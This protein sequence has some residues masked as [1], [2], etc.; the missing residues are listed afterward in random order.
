MKITHRHCH[1]LAVAEMFYLYQ[2][3]RTSSWWR[4]CFL[5]TDTNPDIMT[6]L[7]S[8][9]DW[10]RRLSEIANKL[11]AR[12]SEGEA[13]LQV[14]STCSEGKLVLEQPRDVKRVNRQDLLLKCSLCE[15]G[16]PRTHIDVIILYPFLYPNSITPLKNHHFPN[17]LHILIVVAFII[18]I[19]SKV[20]DAHC[21]AMPSS[22]T[23]TPDP[24]PQTS[25]E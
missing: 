13:L 18:M 24:D 3:S 12:C 23:P 9:W 6:F 14:S 15:V 19:M 20:S 25:L 10:G 7:A 17:Y 11:C 21:T 4:R 22:Y 5:M 2:E 16:T 1:L 8:N